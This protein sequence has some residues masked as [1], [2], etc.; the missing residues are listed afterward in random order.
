MTILNLDPNFQP[1]G[2]GIE[3]KSFVFPSGC[4]V[5]IKDINGVYSKSD[6]VMITTRI[7]SSDDVMLLLMATDALKR[8]GLKNI[9][10]FIPYLPYARQDRQ[11]VY[12]EPLSLKVFA[13]LLNSQGYSKVAVYDVHSETSLALINNSV[14]ISN[15]DFVSHILLGKKDYFII[16]PDAGAYKKIF[17]LCQAVRY[18]GEIVMCNKLRDLSNGVIRSMTVSHADLGGKDCYIIDDICDGGGTFTGLAAELKERNVGKINLI[19]SHGIFSKGVEALHGID[20]VYTT[21]AFKDVEQTQKVT[22]VKLSKGL[23]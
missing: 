20:H 16:S 23:L 3:F 9:E 8:L 17:K 13:D 12:G 1:H 5:H 21:N 10:L 19:V 6:P 2:V 15:H 4:E 11:M 22:Q 7:K 14:C 18:E